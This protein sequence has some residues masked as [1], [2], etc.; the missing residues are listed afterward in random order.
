MP[1]I[2]TGHIGINVTDVER[3]ANF[4]AQAFGLR[5]LGRSN[6]GDERRYAFLGHDGEL[7]VTLWEQ[8]TGSFNVSAPGL[9][10][11][12]FMAED[13]AH[14]RAAR[15]RLRDMGTAFIHDEVVPH[16]EGASS[17][18]IFFLDPDGTRLEIFAPS[19]AEGHA[20]SGDAP[21]CGFF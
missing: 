16:S 4:Y 11:L 15:D 10:H 12:S 1:T 17:G 8:A 2:R 13:I 20:P 18:G 3:S 9:H 7:V 5:V 14:V 21:T 6:E 19:G